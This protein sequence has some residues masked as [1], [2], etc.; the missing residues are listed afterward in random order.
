MNSLYERLGGRETVD[1]VVDRL[2]GR[3]L[4]DNRLN[5]FFSGLDMI[6]QRRHMKLFMAYAFGGLPTYSG[7]SLRAVHRRPV[8]EMALSDSH[9]DAIMEHLS[10]SLKELGFPHELIAE[11]ITIV[12]ATRD[13][14]LNK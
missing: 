6:R 12:E 8:E 11:A 13:D 10:D 1:E 9:F 5:D 4:A 3:V 2:Y 14:V 7:E